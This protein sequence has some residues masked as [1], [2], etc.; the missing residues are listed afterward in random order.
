MESTINWGKPK[1]EV[2][3]V[4]ADGTVGEYAEW[5]TPV[6]DST[7]LT[8]ELGEELSAN[9][10][11]GEAIDKRR[12]KGTAYLEL[13]LYD[14]KGQD[15]P[16]ADSDGIVSGL[17]AVRVTPEDPACSGRVIEKCTVTM[18]ETYNAND[19]SRLV[20]R[21]DALKPKTGAMVKPFTA[22]SLVVAPTALYFGNAA[23]S[24]GKTLTVTSTANPTV[25]SSDSWCTTS[26]SGKVVTVKVAAN[27]GGTL[28]TAT[29]TITADGKTSRV[30]VTQI[31]A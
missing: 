18:T 14:V 24:T 1:I 12:K 15:R 17:Y 30:M 11:G 13:S 6:E 9:I 3:P 5:P 4:S 28:R 2:A 25:T 8:T 20:Y 21:F 26:V 19:G 7:S 31:P 22:N 10:E 16:L 23:D 27:S 29:V